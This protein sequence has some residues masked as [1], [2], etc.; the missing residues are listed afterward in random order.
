MSDLEYRT[1]AQAMLDPG[2]RER[3][4]DGSHIQ[5]VTVELNDSGEHTDQRGQPIDRPAVRCELRTT[6]AR[7]LAYTLLAL[8]ERADWR[9]CPP[10]RAAS[11]PLPRRPAR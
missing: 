8:A 7:L 5:L 11:L 6:E 9:R 10:A 2:A 3:V 4:I 1:D